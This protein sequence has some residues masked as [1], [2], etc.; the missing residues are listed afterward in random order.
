MEILLGVGGEQASTGW[1]AEIVVLAIVLE[2]VASTEDRDAHTADR[3]DRLWDVSEP[4]TPRPPL[5][6]AGEGGIGRK[7]CF[8]GWDDLARR[9]GAP[10]VVLDDLGHDAE[11]DLEG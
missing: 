2:D 1:A 7:R 5:P 10:A 3:I 11:G 8:F 9:R 4:L 6:R